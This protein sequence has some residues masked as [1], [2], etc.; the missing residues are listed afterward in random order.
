MKVHQIQLGP[1]KNFIYIIE[2]QKKAIL[3]DPAWDVNKIL[4]FLEKNSLEL[5][6][7]LL[8]H[9]HADHVNGLNKV[10]DNYL[11]PVYISKYEHKSLVPNIT[12]INFMSDHQEIRFG[13]KIVKCLHTPG[14][15]PGCMCFLIDN[16]LISGDTLFVDGCGRCDLAN[17]N[18][19]QMYDSLKLKIFNL[20]DDT[21]IYP[22]HQYSLK[23]I[24]TLK[25]QKETNP[26][27][28]VIN[29][30]DDFI[31]KRMK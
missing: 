30:K 3:V 26:Y 22:G 1:M 21:I 8:T 20:S 24:D 11:V 23:K 17:S 31:K 6:F 13:D 18:V 4:E 2:Y 15:T 28:K 14:H 29:S 16:H 9:G 12:N 27:L 19:E 7:I 10:L 25:N 5:Q